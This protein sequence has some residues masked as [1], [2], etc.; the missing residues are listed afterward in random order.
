[1]QLPGGTH[2]SLR[3]VDRSVFVPSPEPGTSVHGGSF[4]TTLDTNRLMSLHT[5]SSRSDI[6]SHE[7]YRFSED[8]G[9]T[10]SEA[11]YI[12]AGEST[13]H[14]MKRRHARCGYLDPHTGRF[15]KIRNEAVL[16]ND[17]VAEFMKWNTVHYAVSVDGGR[18]ELYDTP[19]VAVGHDADHPLPNVTRG[20][21]CFMLGDWT[22]TPIT[23]PDGAILQPVQIS[24]TGPD[25]EYHNPGA[26]FTYTDCGVIRGTWRDDLTIAWDLSGMV[27]ADPE[28]STRGLIEPT[29]ARLADGR[30]L[31]VMRGSN[32]A[33][34][35][36]PG[37]RW[38]SLSEDDGNCWSGAQPWTYESGIPF[39][40]PSSCSQLVTHSGGEIYWIGN[41]LWRAANGKMNMKEQ[42]FAQAYIFMHNTSSTHMR[43]VPNSRIAPEK[44]TWIIQNN[45]AIGPAQESLPVL[46][47]AP[48]KQDAKHIS[49]YNAY[50]SGLSNN[51]WFSGKQKASSLEE[52]QE[53]TGFEMHSILA[54]LSVF[55]KADEEAV[56]AKGKQFVLPGSVDLSPAEGSP[57][58]D[59][60]AVIPGINDDFKGKAPDIG[61][62]EFVKAMPVFGPRSAVQQE[63]VRKVQSNQSSVISNQE[64]EL[65]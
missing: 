22:C 50:R 28:R 55:T 33:R 43:M 42:M 6:L 32:D 60:G 64:K 40:S 26:G 12:P 57:V 56:F 59:A 34:P 11:T 58:I 31:M 36:L 37:Y 10:W 9:K 38:F 8:N 14:G 30:L 25:G 18:T 20:R 44:T 3:L 13:P 51:P 2:M 17:E 35:E 4:Y 21:N 45:L 52:F 1:M 65:E 53:L 23:L 48:G 27:I 39:H 24:P 63:R 19:L 15:L 29:I 49:D 16:P 47:L 7:F 46:R 61:A 41:I 5:Y 62:L 54:D